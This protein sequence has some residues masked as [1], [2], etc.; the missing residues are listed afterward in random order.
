MKKVSHKGVKPLEVLSGYAA[1]SVIKVVIP[2]IAAC[3][4][5]TFAGCSGSKSAPGDLNF[6]PTETSRPS[7]PPLREVWDVCFVEGVRVGYMQTTYYRAIE[8]GQSVMWIEDVMHFAITRFGEETKQEV[9]YTS[10]ETLDGHLIRFLSEMQMGRQSMQTTGRVVGKRLEMETVTQGKTT[11]SVIDWSPEYGGFYAVDQSLLDKPMQPGQRRTV[12]ALIAP[13]NQ[14][15]TVE[16]LAR[17]WQQTPLLHGNYELLRIDAMTILPDGQKLEQTSWTD[18]TG[19]ILKMRS[20]TM[21]MEFI[22]ATKAEALEKTDAAQLDIGLRTTVKLEKPLPGGH[23]AKRAVYRVHLDGSDPSA[24]F[25][26]G[27]AQKIKSI[28]PHT[29]EITVF[30]VRPEKKGIGPI[31]RNGPEG[32]LHK[33]DPSPFSDPPT[34]ADREANNWIQSDNPKIVAL[35]KE[36]AGNETDPWQTAVKLERFVHQYIKQKDF[37][38]A[39]STAAEVADTREGDCTEHAVLLVALCRAR[40]IPARVAI[41]LVY[42]PASQAFGYHMW[43]EVYIDNTPNSPRPLGEGK[44]EGDASTDIVRQW[45][46]IDATLAKGGIGADHLEVG[47]GNLAGASAYSSFLPV[48]QV[49]GR[50]KIE[51]VEAE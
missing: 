34:K 4:L 35:A 45:I 3:V 8:A 10:I 13:F 25:P 24:V 38:Q 49:V 19:D 28:D 47:R 36:A 20:P 42:M 7:G 12:Q 11:S 9:S 51:V 26:T 41:G 16:L 40:G 44:G 1:F 23:D 46:S 14:L 31:Y 30:A 27:P 39:F 29:A 21:S 6:S 37:S 22:R 50:L 43:T 48:V 33:L 2:A 32:A 5:W 15:G 17:D 18:H